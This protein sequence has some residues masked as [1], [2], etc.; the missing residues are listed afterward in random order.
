MATQSPQVNVIRSGVFQQSIALGQTYLTIGRA[1][2]NALCLSDDLS[3]S[4]YHAQIAYTANEYVITDVG[5]SDGTYVNGQRLSPQVPQRLL[6]GDM[7]RMGTEFELKFIAPVAQFNPP[8]AVPHEPAI[9]QQY[10]TVLGA[11]FGFRGLPPNQAA[12]E[13]NL[14]GKNEFSFGRDP[15][16]DMTI[17]HPS[18]SRNHSQ[19]RFENGSY[20]LYDLTSTNGT[21]VN[22]QQVLGQRRLVVGDS[23]RIGPTS[24]VFQL[25]QTLLRTNEEG[26]L[27]VD[28]LNLNKQ[29]RKDLN[30]LNNISLTILPREFVAIAGVSGGGKSTLMDSL[31]G[32]RPATSGTV[33]VNGIDLYRNFNAYRAEIGYVPQKD[34]VH[35][36]LTVEQ[37]LDFAAQLRMPA[38][39][40]PAE[41]RKRVDEVLRELNLTHRRA[42][43]IYSLSGGQLKRVSIGVELLTKPSLFFLDEATSGLDPGT[44]TELMQLLRELADQGRTILLV[45]HATENVML[46]DQVIFM[47]RGGNLAYY[48]PPQE[49][50]NYFGVERFNEI[51]RK[52]ENE[53]TPED[54]KQRYLQ[55]PQCQK[56][57]LGRQQGVQQ[58]GASGQ[59]TSQRNQ[60]RPGATVRRISGLKQFLILSKRNIAILTR[61]RIG[62]ALMLLVAPLLG[63]LDFVAWPK[64]LFDSGPDGQPSLTVSMLFTM[65]LIAVM[66]GGLATMREIVKELDIY[67]RER[68]IGLKILPYVFSKVWVAVLLAIY[69]AFIFIL[70]KAIAVDIPTE[71]TVLVSLFLTMLLVTI[72][73][74]LMGL[75][76]SAVSPNQSVAPMIVLVFIVPQI[77]FGGGVLPVSTFG[78][79]GQVLNNTA[80]TKWPFEALMTITEFGTDVAGDQCWAIPKEER[81]ALSNDEK[82]DCQCLGPNVFKRCKFP[83]VQQFYDP[84]IDQPAPTKPIE[85]DPPT[86]EAFEQYRED[87]DVWSGEFKDW[88]VAYDKSISRAEGNINGLFE[89]F[90]QAFKVNVTGHWIIMVI[91]NGILLGLILLTQKIKDLF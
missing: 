16:N 83:G 69:Q 42:I 33:L 18:V 52:V 32:F 37:A 73:G 56:Y 70:F 7:V 44:E 59:S 6:N 1:P 64:T 66:V 3:V 5:S 49:A 90:G 30:L 63:L 27:R 9:G 25:N 15:A 68:I 72:G 47:A 58:T 26:N 19:I 67:K 24:F 60:P 39:T 61:D 13:L 88:Q 80:L 82:D 11:D 36:E 71:P 4:R 46:C 87:L 8:P 10:K 21:Y 29:I 50:L 77:L 81:E 53:L 51:Y 34:I 41:R 65:V 86:P 23:I 2:D 55:S 14:Q 91:Y 17:D 76:G 38:D 89:N 85:P 78:A 12:Q 74:M 31:T 75:L 48:G 54:W 40:T 22:G 62:L 79:P 45:T 28:A 35:T 20:T 57:V 84:V 43:P